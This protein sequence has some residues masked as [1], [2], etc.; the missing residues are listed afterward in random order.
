MVVYPSSV[1]RL[2]DRAVQEKAKSAT[3]FKDPSDLSNRFVDVVDV[4][5]HETGNSGVE[6]LVGKRQRS[7]C[8]TTVSGA[9][10]SV[11]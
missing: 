5:E 2:Q 11:R 1:G 4:F 9:S 6:R 10:A 8:S 3:E 7:W